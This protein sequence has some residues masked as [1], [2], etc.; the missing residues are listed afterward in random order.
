MATR[1]FT[2]FNAAT[3]VIT[4][5]RQDAIDGIRYN[6]LATYVNAALNGGVG[7]HGMIVQED[8][9]GNAIS[10]ITKNAD[11]TVAVKVEWTYDVTGDN[12]DTATF[13]YSEDNGAT[14]EEIGTIT[15]TYDANGNITASQWVYA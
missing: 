11:D 5:T 10:G 13:S 1:P 4:D 2:R 8:A 15:Y 6:Q 7:W 14:W 12:C 9:N 3:P